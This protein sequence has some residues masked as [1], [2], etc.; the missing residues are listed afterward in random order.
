MGDSAQILSDASCTLEFVMRPGLKDLRPMSSFGSRRPI[1]CSIGEDIEV[2]RSLS[3]YSGSQAYD[4]RPL[5]SMFVVAHSRQTESV[6]RL[7]PPSLPA[8]SLPLPWAW[9][10]GHLYAASLPRSSSTATSAAHA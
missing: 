2:V 5:S 1:W 10:P 9:I 6:P 8:S 7:P 4:L 3:G